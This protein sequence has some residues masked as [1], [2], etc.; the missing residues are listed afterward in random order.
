MKYQTPKGTRD[1]LPEEMELR[2]GVI[3]TLVSMY[4]LYGFREWDGPAFEY[5]DTLVAKSGELVVD[6]IYAFKDRG[7]RNLGLRFELTTSLARIIAGNSQIKKPLRVFNIGKVWRYERPQ[8]GRFR[9]FLQADT[10][11]FG[12]TSMLCEVDLLTMAAATLKKLKI[13]NSVIL[14]NNRKILEALLRSVGIKDNY[15]AGALRSLDKLAKIGRE[16]VK[17]EFETQKIST[18]QFENLMNQINIVGDNRAKLDQISQFLID[19]NAGMEGIEELRQ[20]IGLLDKSGLDTPIQV[21]FSLVRGLDYYTGPIFEIKSTDQKELGS[22]AGGGRYDQLVQVLGGQ[23]TPAVGISFGIERLI[24]IIKKREGYFDILSPVEVFICYQTPDVLPIVL[25]AAKKFREAGITTEFDL[26]GR[27][28][29]K[30]LAYASTIN[31]KYSFIVFSAGEQKLKEM[32]TQK[33]D[34]MDVSSA[35]SK[36]TSK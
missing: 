5:L 31:A 35:I 27:N 22:F 2:R 3:N 24:E 19:D 30:Q 25:N 6:E 4:Y 16:E 33:E 34:V 21:D 15:K 36:I 18:E 7:G 10:D 11:I 8:A 28:L 9:E 13:V 1:F 14:L 17:R 23:T 12:S 26:T 32:A 29:S 20:I